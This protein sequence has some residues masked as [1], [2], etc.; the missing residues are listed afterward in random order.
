M[1]LF[2]PFPFKTVCKMQLKVFIIFFAVYISISQA[3]IRNITA[4][5]GGVVEPG[6]NLTLSYNIDEPWFM[7]NWF[8]YE[9][10]ND[11]HPTVQY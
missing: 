1:N 7:C 6:K 8:R 11:S 9:S 2:I 10:V 5:E 4:T 3:D